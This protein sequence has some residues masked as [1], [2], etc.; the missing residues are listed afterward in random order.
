MSNYRCD[1]GLALIQGSQTMVLK[2]FGSDEGLLQFPDMQ[3][4]LE[5]HGLPMA[6]PGP[7]FMLSVGD[8]LTSVWTV[9]VDFC[10]LINYADL[11]AQK[12]STMTFGHIM[13]SVMYPLH[14]MDLASDPQ[15]DLIRLGLLGFSSSVFLQ[16][17][18]VGVKYSHFISAFRKRLIQ[19]MEFEA[20]SRLNLWLILI[21]AIS[22][23]DAKDDWWLQPLFHSNLKVCGI[24]VW[25][26]MRVLMED[27]LWIGLVHD[28]PGQRIFERFMANV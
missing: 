13:T 27:F 12:I 2:T 4:L 16:W 19:V 9:M 8:D 18:T 3:S 11:T 6:Y 24:K 14:A 15:K 5:Q 20:S 28:K 10:T 21:G 7:D 23:F 22:L 26:D 25:E 17:R 1:L